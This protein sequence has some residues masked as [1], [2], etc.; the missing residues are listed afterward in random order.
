MSAA[1]GLSLLGA[2][3]VAAMAGALSAWRLAEVWHPG[4]VRDY[5]ATG[6]FAGVA[7]SAAV[8]WWVLVPARRLREEERE[9]ARWRERCEDLLRAMPDGLC[10]IGP[11]FVVCEPVSPSLAQV[12]PG[13]LRPGANLLEALEPL[14]DAETLTALR[15]YLRQR[16][17]A[18]PAPDPRGAAPNPLAE[19][20]LL[21]QPE[22][23]PP[24]SFRFEP[25]MRSGTVAYLLVIV[26]DVSQ[27]LREAR[28]SDEARQRSQAQ[29]ES[30]LRI[31]GGDLGPVRACV[32]FAERAL[33]RV[34]ERL[35]RMLAADG[36]DER[37]VIRHYLLDQVRAMA[38]AAE[39]IGLD[40]LQGPARA[41]EA[42][43]MAGAAR[44]QQ[45]PQTAASLGALAGGVGERLVLLRECLKV[46]ERDRGRLESVAASE[47]DGL[48]DRLVEAYVYGESFAQA[49]DADAPAATHGDAPPAPAAQARPSPDPASPEA[50][51]SASAVAAPAA[52]AGDER[53]AAA[54]APLWIVVRPG[55]A[56]AHAAA[57]GE[58]GALAYPVACAL[59][60]SA[61]GAA[62]P[63]TE[64]SVLWEWSSLA[65]R[66][67][68]AYDKAAMLDVELEPFARLSP[69]EATMLSEVGK[70]LIAN[71]VLHGIEP[72]A[73]RRRRGKTSTGSVRLRLSHDEEEGWRFCVR[74]DGG[75]LESGALRL[76]LLRE[77]RYRAEDILRMDEREVLLKAFEPG[78]TRSGPIAAGIDGRN[79][80]MGMGL[81]IVAERVSGLGAEL[82]FSSV[83]GQSTELRI[84]WPSA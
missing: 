83:L 47:A 16:L 4:A 24:L 71:A 74:D 46:L 48:A 20:M 11:D 40:L 60:Q 19:A 34:N 37:S 53:S 10:L 43:L 21:R 8:A 49:Q 77:G 54:A 18:G 80:G 68:G 35:P 67:A 75:G 70:E 78:V 6:L 23:R 14:L 45:D 33:Q 84:V 2:M 66:L 39:E 55:A 44:P 62:R 64:R 32:R 58:S 28:E 82:S 65:R 51:A 25:V 30:L 41:L 22:R 13:G 42:G 26:S 79:L 52:D 17:R 7:A 81:P 56:S 59:A 69:A 57:H 36:I 15:V 38:A 27:R 61:G 12:L 9:R 5:L 73:T 72:V 1:F 50:P 3:L 76:A 29:A 63:P 31:I